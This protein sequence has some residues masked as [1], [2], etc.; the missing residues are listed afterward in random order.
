VINE[1]FHEITVRFSTREKCGLCRR[2]AKYMYV[3]LTRI[4]YRCEE[5][6]D[7]VISPVYKT[8]IWDE[9]A[10]AWVSID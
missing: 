10:K 6:K 3:L 5:H 8:Y 9:K 1:C 2:K 7:W 4:V